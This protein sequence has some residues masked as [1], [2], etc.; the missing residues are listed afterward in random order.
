[1]PRNFVSVLKRN[2]FEVQKLEIATGA[3]LVRVLGELQ[4]RLRGRIASTVSADRV[5]D[6]SVLRQML[7]ETQA[8]ISELERRADGLF[9]TAQKDAAELASGHIVEEIAR[10]SRAFES[11]AIHVEV[12]AYEV[13]R[14]PPQSLL[15]DHFATS[16]NRYGQDLLNG[17]RRQL[18]LSLRT[19]ETAGAMA[20]K[21]S[22]MRGPMGAVGSDNAKRL[23]RTEVSQ[24][25]GAAH[26]SSMKQAEKEV[27]SL[28][29]VW[30]HIG[31][32]LCAI[33]GP[34]H[35]TERPLDG[36][37][38]IRSGRKTRQV[39]HAPGHPNCACRTSA[40]KP[41]WRK[42]LIDSGYLKDQPTTDEPGRA[43][44]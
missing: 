25:Y 40:M 44:L 24:A 16:V 13:L 42:G 19:G 11:Q 43:A 17:V 4:D 41:S 39:A 7:N 1:M 35:G 20:S 28:K 33:C 31:S 23:M 14:D 2:S 15:A 21:I 12:D 27:P 5:V 30:L 9:G 18:I 6:A 34:L 22:G 36:T 8:V 37:W 29:K 26:H 10:L 3:D 38:T 32:Y